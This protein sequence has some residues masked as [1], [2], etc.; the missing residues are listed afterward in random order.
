MNNDVFLL[1]SKRQLKAAIN[2]LRE[3]ATLY[4]EVRA[5]ERIEHIA[6]DYQL[7]LD[8]MERGFK[9]ERRQELYD[10][11]LHRM[12]ALESDTRV[13]DKCRRSSFMS[14]ALRMTVKTN[15]DNE[16]VRYSLENFVTDVAMLSLQS[17]DEQKQKKQQLFERHEAFMSELFRK[18]WLSTQWGESTAQFYQ[19]LL[20]SPAVDAGDVLIMESAITLA[21]RMQFDFLKLRTLLNVYT[22]ATDER[23]RQRALVGWVLSLSDDPSTALY[24][25]D[26]ERM[27]GDVCADENVRR[28]LLELQMQ[29][30][31]CLNAEQDNQTIQSDIFPSIMKNNNLRITRFGIE[32]KEDDPM[33]DILDPGAADR[34]MEE[35]E[36]TMQRM[37]DMQKQGADIYFGGFSLMKKHAF[38]NDISHWLTPFY[39][40][41]PALRA[42][43][44]R[45]QGTSLLQNLVENGPFCDSDKYSF[46]LTIVQV[47][48][49][50]PPSVREM[51]G[52]AEALGPIAPREEQNS[53]AWFRRMYLQDLYRFYRLFPFKHEF[54]SPFDNQ[55]L[56]FA[57][58]AFSNV[59][60]GQQAAEL[61]TFLL[62]YRRMNELREL[63][64]KSTANSQSARLLLLQAKC[65]QYFGEG[66][67]IACYQKVLDME[68][69]NEVAL[70]NMGQHHFANEHY[71]EAEQC[72]RKL[73]EIHP[74]KKSYMMSLA[75]ALLYQGQTDEAMPLVYKL[76]YQYPGDL[77]VKRTQAW[78]LMA[79]NRLE[80]AHETYQRILST[81]S[82]TTEG[83]PEPAAEDYLNAGYCEWFMGNIAEAK[84]LF[85]QYKNKGQKSLRE[86]FRRDKKTLLAHGITPMDMILMADLTEH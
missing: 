64:N 30:F 24:A 29:I 63:L 51:V 11:L 6:A 81:P 70:R 58:K 31:L 20:L 68:P 50:L 60:W 26:I 83:A 75:V 32:E 62:K 65:S 54:N 33:Q 86:H 18:L 5:V 34:A 39:K 77:N 46:A 52:T 80:Q 21:C 10:D 69:D 1:L 12:C 56:F 37:M 49:T 41:N 8:Y 7:M 47:I 57:L 15:W 36:K 53:P 23:I 16:F 9:D 82:G 27:V 2:R 4:P 22:R 38:F 42:V 17:D 73:L 72:Y 14:N 79:Q 35:M 13:A 74:D 44:E 76:D 84:Q 78:G 25:D 71:A 48:D 45:M 55:P 28:E 40:D 61:G 67:D 43:V 66:N 19:D 59:D 3:Y 85:L